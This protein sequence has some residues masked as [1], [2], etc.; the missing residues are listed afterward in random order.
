MGS[1]ESEQS[2]QEK[3]LGERS[4]KVSSECKPQS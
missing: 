3:S 1:N 4:L 2:A